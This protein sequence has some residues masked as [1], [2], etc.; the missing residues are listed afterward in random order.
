MATDMV[1]RRSNL[2]V[3]RVYLHVTFRSYVFSMSYNPVEQL[4]KELFQ[5]PSSPSKGYLGQLYRSAVMS[6]DKSENDN[7][8]S[9]PAQDNEKV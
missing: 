3:I 6:R 1:C 5:V 9:P 8:P 4:C 7:E 2:V